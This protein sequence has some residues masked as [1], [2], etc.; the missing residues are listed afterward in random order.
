MGVY[1]QTVLADSPLWYWRV[2]F[3]GA[4]AFPSIGTHK[5]WAAVG[6]AAGVQF[7]WSGPGGDAGSWLGISA[8]ALFG[9]SSVTLVPP[10]SMEFWVFQGGHQPG[11]AQTT[12]Q[13]F[14]VNS[15]TPGTNFFG[16]GSSQGNWTT[17]INTGPSSTTS[18]SWS[19]LTWHHVV[20][21]VSATGFDLWVDAASV[22]TASATMATLSGFNLAGGRTESHPEW[23]AEY[24]IYGS[25]LTATAVGNH[26]AAGSLAPPAYTQGLA[27]CG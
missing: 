24:A 3:T 18:I 15:P 22:F 9:Q 20:F 26:Y 14:Q 16:V 1:S 25:A 12:S 8:V 21:A 4:Q 27:A 5:E 19:P 7:G 11:T 10:F 17:I 6:T 2:P 23:L 13:Y